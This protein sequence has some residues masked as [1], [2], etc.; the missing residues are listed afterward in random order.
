MS[1]NVTIAIPLEIFKGIQAG[2][3]KDWT[4]GN[5]VVLNAI[6]DAV[7]A[8]PNQ[9]QPQAKTFRGPKQS[10]KPKPKQKAKPRQKQSAEPRPKQMAYSDE[11]FQIKIWGNCHTFMMRVSAQ[12]PVCDL[13]REIFHKTGTPMYHFNLFNNGRKLEHFGYLDEGE[14][15]IL[16]NVS[17]AAVEVNLGKFSLICGSKVWNRESRCHTLH[18]EHFWEARGAESWKRLFIGSP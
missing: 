2:T 6:A 11:E 13:A 8:M 16:G 9:L 15:M 14:R 10:G 7:K 17:R 1:V 12:T 18:S 4:A 5:N 3:I